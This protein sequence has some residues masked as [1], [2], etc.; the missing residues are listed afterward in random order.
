MICILLYGD[1]VLY[2]QVH[3]TLAKLPVECLA[4]GSSRLGTQFTLHVQG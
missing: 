1:V 3:R 2:V 4:D